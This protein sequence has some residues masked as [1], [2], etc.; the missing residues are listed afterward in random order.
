MWDTQVPTASGGRARSTLQAWA[1]MH[2]SLG[3]QEARIVATGISGRCCSSQAAS[4]CAALLPC[5]R[6]PRDTEEEQEE[7]PR[8]AWRRGQATHHDN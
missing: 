2:G 1:G 5:R 7:G 8:R 3:C 4:H 6:P